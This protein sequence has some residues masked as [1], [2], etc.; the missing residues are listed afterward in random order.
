MQEHGIG[1]FAAKQPGTGEYRIPDVILIEAASFKKAKVKK[2]RTDS[3]RGEIDILKYATAE[4][5]AYQV[6]MRKVD[7]AKGGVRE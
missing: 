3:R 7:C 4:I 1:K 2:A 5:A 6:R